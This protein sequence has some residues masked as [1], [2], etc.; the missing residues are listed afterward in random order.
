MAAIWWLRGT[1]VWGRAVS[2]SLL[3][4]DVLLIDTLPTIL[5]KN[6]R[7]WVLT[8]GW[9][10]MTRL[11]ESGFLST[12]NSAKEV[13]FVILQTVPKTLWLL[14]QQLKWPLRPEALQQSGVTS[15]SRL[16]TASCAL[17][18]KLDFRLTPTHRG[19]IFYC[20]GMTK[21][22][23]FPSLASVSW[24]QRAICIF[25]GLDTGFET[26]FCYLWCFFKFFFC[27]LE[28]HFLTKL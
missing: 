26:F 3:S 21:P 9:H 13:V 28:K 27:K 18:S 8:L 11:W 10:G 2:A 19:F 20:P 25:T 23:F 22:F 4:W 16:F 17:T 14:P 5:Q 7:A 15:G 24:T 6:A 12:E 1:F